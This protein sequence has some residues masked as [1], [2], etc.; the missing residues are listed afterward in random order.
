MEENL[1][2]VNTP[3]APLSSLIIPPPDLGDM[4][5]LLGAMKASMTALE[6]TFTVLSSH[7][8]NLTGVRSATEAAHEVGF[9]SVPRE[10]IE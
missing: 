9:R 1:T 10:H 6:D 4:D 8:T 2:I 7:T 5:E 3:P